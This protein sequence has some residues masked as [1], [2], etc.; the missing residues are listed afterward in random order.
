[1]RSIDVA[2]LP[3]PELES[4]LDEVAGHRLKSGIDAARTLLEGRT[5]W[6]VTPSA[7][8]GAGPA[9][10]VA[11]LVGYALGLGVTARWLAL[12]APAD[13]LTLS[14]VPQTTKSEWKRPQ[15]KTK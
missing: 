14:R 3:I 11:P 6:T 10:T 2:S 15:R 1:M 9:E 8:A 12:D 4:H 7:A 13:S 5:V